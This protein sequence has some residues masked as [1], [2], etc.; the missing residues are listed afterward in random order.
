[1]FL[2]QETRAKLLATAKKESWD[3][4]E[5]DSSGIIHHPPPAVP[6]ERT[7]KDV[8][9]YLPVGRKSI[10]QDVPDT[11]KACLSL[12]IAKYGVSIENAIPVVEMVRESI[13]KTPPNDPAATTESV[14]K[15]PS[16]LRKVMLN[17]YGR[18]FV[19]LCHK[20]CLSTH[21]SLLID[22]SNDYHQRN[23]IAI[24]MTGRYK[25]AM[26]S[27]PIRFCEPIDHSASTQLSEI[28]QTFEEINNLTPATARKLSVLDLFAI[29]FD[30][31]SSNTG[32]KDGLAGF[33]Y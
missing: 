31:T 13:S 29:V 15:S 24:R 19:L 12:L 2:S 20:I 1:L 6:R 18:L 33:F 25:G 16:L 17:V 26:W 27:Y 22:G 32:M 14:V 21:L 4:N 8:E 30:T 5:C 10:V 28:E 23:P 3:L 9:D 7:L 11:E